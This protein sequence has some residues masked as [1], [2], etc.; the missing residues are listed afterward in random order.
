MRG[1]FAAGV[2]D[3]LIHLRALK[4]AWGRGDVQGAI[5]MLSELMGSV[6]AEDSSARVSVVDFLSTLR[7]EAGPAP[8]KLEHCL[9]LVMVLQR[10]WKVGG[11]ARARRASMSQ[12]RTVGQSIAC[13]RCG[14]FRVPATL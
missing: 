5:G 2:G 9:E 12:T 13:L 8:V 10:L 1:G 6:T 11:V 3:R 14:S 7:L 4:G